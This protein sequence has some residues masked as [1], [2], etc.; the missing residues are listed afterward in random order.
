MNTPLLE[1]HLSSVHFNADVW[2]FMRCASQAII[3][4]WV[5]TS[6]SRRLIMSSIFDFNDNN[7]MQY[8]INS[9]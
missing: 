7:S 3:R 9:F 4:K 1:R 6:F 8:L 2:S 5:S